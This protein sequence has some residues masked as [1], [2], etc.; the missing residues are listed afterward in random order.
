MYLF[1]IGS[2]LISDQWR[3]ISWR[4]LTMS[5]NYTHML[6]SADIPTH[7]HIHTHTH[8]YTHTHTH[9][10][11]HTHTHTHNRRSGHLSR[12]TV[13][14]GAQNRGNTQQQITLVDNRAGENVISQVPSVWENTLHLYPTDCCLQTYGEQNMVI[15]ILLTISNYMSAIAV[16]VCVISALKI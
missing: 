15:H 11:T 4:H 16:Y 1:C 10:Y 6:K 7:T 9:T 14:C 3:T 12:L 8:T 13:W 5:L 2:S